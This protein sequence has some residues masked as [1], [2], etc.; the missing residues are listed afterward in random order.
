MDGFKCSDS[1]FDFL[2]YDCTITH[3]GLEVVKQPLRV[4]RYGAATT[5]DA[6]DE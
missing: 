2:S 3:T 4:V 1:R 5:N 6:P